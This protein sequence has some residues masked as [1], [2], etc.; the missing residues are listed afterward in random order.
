VDVYG[1]QTYVH[2][3]GRICPFCAQ[4]ELKVYMR[5]P[6]YVPSIHMCIHLKYLY[7]YSHKPR[8]DRSVHTCA[9]SQLFLCWIL[10]NQTSNCAPVFVPSLKLIH[11]CCCHAHVRLGSLIEPPHEIFPSAQMHWT[12]QEQ[13]QRVCPNAYLSSQGCCVAYHLRAVAKQAKM[14]ASST[15]NFSIRPCCPDRATHLSKFVA[16]HALCKK[17]VSPLLQS[18][19]LKLHLLPLLLLLMK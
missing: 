8:N 17:G 3:H 5:Q 2:L 19:A 12:G 11:Q 1:I 13:R 15:D 18:E 9:H 14:H 7:A 10:K 6:V 4:L 16:Q